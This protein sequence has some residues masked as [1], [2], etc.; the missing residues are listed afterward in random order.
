MQKT[1]QIYTIKIHNIFEDNQIPLLLIII[2]TESKKFKKYF[3]LFLKYFI[4]VVLINIQNNK[5]E[6]FVH[7]NM[8]K[9]RTI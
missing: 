3:A 8:P 2:I 4:H 5:N 9:K 1:K 6:S 7:Q